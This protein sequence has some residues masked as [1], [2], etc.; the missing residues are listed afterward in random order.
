ML[1]SHGLRL[2]S[3]SQALQ[4]LPDSMQPCRH[5]GLRATSPL[6]LALISS[7]CPRAIVQPPVN[8]DL[9][10]IPQ[11]PHSM[12]DA[13]SR[14]RSSLGFDDRTRCRMPK[15]FFFF[16]GFWMIVG[17][18]RFGLALWASVGLVLDVLKKSWAKV[19]LEAR[20][21]FRASSG[22]MG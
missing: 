7:L 4:R 1:S 20:N 16:F 10:P 21:S 13:P 8:S 9:P 6:P 11:C 19:R 5:P 14:L 15:V 22:H 3:R 2:F 18:L 12:W 17:Q